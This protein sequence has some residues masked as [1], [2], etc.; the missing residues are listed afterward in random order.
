M[1][2][3]RLPPHADLNALTRALTQQRSEGRPIIDLTESN[4]TRAGFTYPSDLLTALA[5]DTALR[6]EP[7]AF[8]LIAENASS[9]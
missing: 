3:R 2:S 1:A 6:Y 4:P 7:H 5:S 9:A 8:G